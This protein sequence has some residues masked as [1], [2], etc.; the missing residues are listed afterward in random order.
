M[1][2]TRVQVLT[3]SKY[4]FFIQG[5]DQNIKEYPLMWLSYDHLCNIPE[6]LRYL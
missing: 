2:Q 3:M 1:V 4:K 6:G 5:Y